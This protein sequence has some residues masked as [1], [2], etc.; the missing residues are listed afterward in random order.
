ML[1]VTDKFLAFE[2]YQ[3]IKSQEQ[4]FEDLSSM[5][6]E[7]PEKKHGGFFNRYEMRKFPKEIQALVRKLV[8]GEVLK[9]YKLADK[10]VIIGLDSLVSVQFDDATRHRLLL[11]EFDVWLNAVVNHLKSHLKSTL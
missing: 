9:P 11:E 10:Y 3:R 4:T 1:R 7:G 2:L 5:Y 8:P 6:G